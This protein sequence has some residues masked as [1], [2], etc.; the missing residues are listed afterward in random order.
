[1]RFA[2]PGG[3]K[4]FSKSK[5][6][7]WALGGRCGHPLSYYGCDHII[8]NILSNIQAIRLTLWSDENIMQPSSH[9]D[10]NGSEARTDVYYVMKNKVT[11]IV[12]L[13]LVWSCG[14]GTVA[15]GRGEGGGADNGAWGHWGSRGGGGGSGKTKYSKEGDWVKTFGNHCAT[16]LDLYSD[17]RG[18]GAHQF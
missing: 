13:F 18:D 17:A 9:W 2:A 5:G 14:G 12:F 6:A 16:P 8:P 15:R 10:F 11:F 7:L 3:W 1:M 4:L